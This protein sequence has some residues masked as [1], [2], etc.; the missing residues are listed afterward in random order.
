VA[1]EGNGLQVFKGHRVVAA[2]SADGGGQLLLEVQPEMPVSASIAY[3]KANEPGHLWHRR[4]SHLG[5]GNL[6]KLPKLVTGLNLKAA[7]AKP[8]EGAVCVPGVESRLTRSPFDDRQTEEAEPLEVLY[9]D[10]AG[11]VT[12]TSKGGAN[13]VVVTKDG[14]SKLLVIKLLKARADAGW[15]LRAVINRLKKTK[16]KPVKQVRFD[17]AGELVNS[18]EMVNFFYKSEG[19]RPEQTLPYT[20]E[21]NEVAERTKRTLF[22][23]TRAVMLAAKADKSL[24]GEVIN[25]VTHA[26]NRS[27]AKDGNHTPYEL[28]YGKKPDVSHL[29]VWSCLAYAL[30]PPGQHCKSESK[31]LEGTHVGYAAE[32]HGLRILSP[33]TERIL[34]RR[35]VVVDETPRED[36]LR[37][38]GLP[39]VDALPEGWSTD[40]LEAGG[41]APGDGPFRDGQG[42]DQTPS[43]VSERANDGNTAKT[44]NT[45]RYASR[46]RDTASAANPAASMVTAEAP[47]GAFKTVAEATARADWDAKPLATYEEA[48]RRPDAWVW[49]QA[50]DEEMAAHTERGTWDLK[51]ASAGANVTGSTWAYDYKHDC[52]GKVNRY[53]SRF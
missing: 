5:A 51:E 14:H 33:V 30:K 35:D 17:G 47:D 10:L 21:A 42:D 38:S 31:V 43:S 45:A 36:L 48:M 39:Q 15:E 1:F 26:I 27:P 13:H 7:Y 19:I 20:P 9:V 8:V 37:G 24:W 4:F 18:A 49:K 50:M 53:R 52:E 40:E 23:R 2:G 44:G 3:G 6:A 41:A 28:L 25:A 29:R 12:P 34:K 46:S 22:K 11:P 16:G 32:G